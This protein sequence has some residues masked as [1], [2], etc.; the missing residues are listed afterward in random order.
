[1]SYDVDVDGDGDNDDDIDD[2][3]ELLSL[4]DNKKKGSHLLSEQ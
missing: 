3:L 4:E 1:M 2:T